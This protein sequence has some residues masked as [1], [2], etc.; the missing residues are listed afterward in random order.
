LISSEPEQALG[1]HALLRRAL[2]RTHAEKMVEEASWSGVL[3]RAGSV[4][5]T[6][7][8]RLDSLPDDERVIGVLSDDERLVA[9]LRLYV[10]GGIEPVPVWLVGDLVEVL[11]AGVTAVSLRR[12]RAMEEQG[13]PLAP[14]YDALEAEVAYAQGDSRRA[15]NLATSALER[16][17]ES[18]G[19]FRARVAAIGA[20]A[21]AD[22]GRNRDALALYEQAM[23]KDGGVFRRL[24][25]RI[26][27]SVR[28]RGGGEVGSRAA[29]MLERSPRVRSDP[30]FQV[31]V[32]GSGSSVEACLLSSHGAQLGCATVDPVALAEQF[33][34]AH[35]EWQE[36]V[37]KAR[38]DGEDVTSLLEEEP[39]APDPA[40]H[41][42]EAF[43]DRVFSAPVTLSSADLASLDGRT[44]TGAEV[45][46]ERF[47]NLLEQAV[48]P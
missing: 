8:A 39:Q 30:G 16:L 38:D 13:T 29:D 17:P 35:A 41:L 1:A 20:E 15:W 12:A 22:T 27:A 4:L 3:A 42:A 45:A 25:L 5:T 2:Q 18:Q 10:R 47:Q 14:Y 32:S 33:A 9:T 19:L 43:H 31:V 11:G 21:A 46:R 40:E 44:T 28:V 6:T 37:Q 48:E 24:G 23:L 7:R 36:K 26:P 34:A